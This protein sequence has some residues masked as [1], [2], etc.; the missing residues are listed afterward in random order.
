MTG[1]GFFTICLIVAI[2]VVGIIYI[3]GLVIEGDKYLNLVKN[4]TDDF[5][6]STIN[7]TK[8]V[9]DFK[10]ILIGKNNKM[11]EIL[12]TTSISNFSFY[13]PYFSS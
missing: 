6:E 13:N 2:S 8:D 7:D 5:V 4:S 11:N 1:K 10:V 9:A 12:N 3:G